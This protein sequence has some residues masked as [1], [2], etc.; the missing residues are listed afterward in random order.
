MALQFSMSVML[1]LPKIVSLFVIMVL[2]FLDTPPSASK[3][4]LHKIDGT[5][6]YI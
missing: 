2:R 3:H 6:N 4:T 1:L 5:P